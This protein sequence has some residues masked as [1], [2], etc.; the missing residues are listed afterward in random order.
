MWKTLNKRLLALLLIIIFSVSSTFIS[1][2]SSYDENAIKAQ[3]N[4]L[5]SKIKDGKLV[6]KKK[7]EKNNQLIDNLT[8]KY[9]KSNYLSEKELYGAMIDDLQLQNGEI[10][11]SLHEDVVIF[12]SVITKLKIK[13]LEQNTIKYIYI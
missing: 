6:A 1:Y 11:L 10:N 13:K 8:L 3:V 12:T 2:G 4:E 7:L 9:K 5:N